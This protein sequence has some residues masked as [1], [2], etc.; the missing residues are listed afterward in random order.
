MFLVIKAYTPMCRYT[1][2]AVTL[3]LPA[4]A[5]KVIAPLVTTAAKRLPKAINEACLAVERRLQRRLGPPRQ[6]LAPFLAAAGR[7]R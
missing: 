1:F 6:A 4:A 7:V 3:C 5:A 2:C